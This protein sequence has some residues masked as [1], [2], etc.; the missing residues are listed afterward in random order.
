ME[1]TTGRMA[2]ALRALKASKGDADYASKILNLY[3]YAVQH[4]GQ[5]HREARGLCEQAM[6]RGVSFMDSVDLP[7]AEGG[8]DE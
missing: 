8:S 6:D 3:D 1:N 7:P 5:S 2:T 4:E